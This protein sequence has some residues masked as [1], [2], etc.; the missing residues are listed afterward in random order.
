[1]TSV[2]GSVTTRYA[3]SGDLSIAYQVHGDGPMDVVFV[4]GFVTNLDVGLEF[5]NIAGVAARLSSFARAIT[6]D[7]RGTGLSDRTAGLPTL[8]E[9][10]DDIRAVMDAV[11]SEKAAVIGMSEGGGAASLFAATY[12][13]RVSALVLWV[14]ALGPPID[15]RSEAVQ[16]TFAGFQNYVG[17]H[18]GDGTALRFL[19]GAGAPVDAAINE[20]FARYERN[21]ATPAAAQ[22]V[23]RWSYTT[24]C[25]PIM[26]A[27]TVPT[28]LVAHRGDPIS[29][30]ALVR[31]TAARIPGARLVETDASSHWSWDIAET[32]DLDAIEE[33][34]TGDLAPRQRADRVLATVL[35]TDI[36]G[37]TELAFQ[38]G[39][40][41]WRRVLDAH[42]H[43]V[44][45]ELHRFDGREL[46]TTGDGFIAAFDGPARAVQ[47][48]HSIVRETNALDI[49]VRA[50]L[51]TGECEVRGTNFA[52]VTMHVGARIVALAGPGEVLVSR[53]VRD[54][55]MG[56][57]IDFEPRGE[58]NLKG[59]P[60][61]TELYASAPA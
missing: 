53:T 11:G 12:P 61:P 30:I 55:V 39:D 38:L 47:C 16:A 17:E 25:R 59:V 41:H 9:R 32:V 42:D 14:T 50:G 21:A 35:Y 4:P 44:R 1:M 10:M 60:H 46:N 3:K 56:S 52:G 40:R 20:L 34:L 23:L 18:W 22:A 36:V 31:E 24:D 54:F 57:G 13:E 51:H 45:R 27:I 15:E 37:S 58:F 33:F 8:A 48:A 29:P 6:F 19:I 5:P 26:D 7:K 2:V 49:A 43:A 28:L